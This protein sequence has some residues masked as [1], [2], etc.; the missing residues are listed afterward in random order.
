MI[1]SNARL[2]TFLCTY[3][4]TQ[5]LL[6]EQQTAQFTHKWEATV[7]LQNLNDFSMA[8]HGIY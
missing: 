8:S 2:I 6:I 4:E 1:S 5:Y 7:K 3:N